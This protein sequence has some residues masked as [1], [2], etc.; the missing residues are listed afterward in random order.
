MPR[1]FA[2]GG[3]IYA[4]NK[5]FGSISHLQQHVAA[6]YLLG[7]LQGAVGQFPAQ[8]CPQNTNCHFCHT[9]QQPGLLSGK[10]SLNTRVTSIS[11]PICALLKLGLRHIRSGW[12][13]FCCCSLQYSSCSCESSEGRG[14]K[15][16]R[17]N[18]WVSLWAQWDWK[19]CHWSQC[20]RAQHSSSLR[21]G[22]VQL[23]SENNVLLLTTAH[24][25]G[26]Y[27]LVWDALPEKQNRTL[28]VLWIF[29]C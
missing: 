17:L 29:S 24:G 27:H 6:R 21:N 13:C 22:E 7:A 14:P 16:L 8:R 19:E 25:P 10:W 28:E 15:T 2:M 23:S 4:S 5:H 11:H 18:S 12:K 26:L 1:C 20:P 9:W 3:T